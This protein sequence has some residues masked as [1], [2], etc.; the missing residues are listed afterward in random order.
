MRNDTRKKFNHYM[1]EVARIN[2]VD[3]AAVLFTVALSTPVQSL[4][5][6]IQL[7]SEFLGRINIIPVN[8]FTILILRMFY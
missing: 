4:E 5:Q 8:I 2:G 1:G 6:K 7:S 3:S